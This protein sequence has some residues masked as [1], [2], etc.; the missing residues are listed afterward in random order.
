MSEATFAFGEARL[1]GTFTPGQ[2]GAAD[3]GIGLLLFNAGVVHRVGAHRINVRLA[4]RMARH[5]VP[6]L[7][8]D[9]A[10]LGDSP[11]ATTG[12]GYR[13]QAVADIRAA[14][15]ELSTR[16]GLQRFALFGFC[17]GGV[18]AY[19]VAQADPRV[20]CT[21]LFDTFMYRT[22]WSLLNR[23]RLSIHEKGFW[24]TVG[25]WLGR[26]PKRLR[27]RAGGNAAALEQGFAFEQPSAADFARALAEL[28][29][30]GTKTA[31]VY[32]GGF[33]DMYNYEGQFADAFRGTGVAEFVPCVYDP[34]LDHNATS[35]AAQERLM[36]RIEHWVREAGSPRMGAAG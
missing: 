19:D 11:R 31:I 6:T 10:G 34:Q 17:S 24:S 30:R 16:T 5:G 18:H 26:L 4:R 3:A 7:R 32:S 23:Y 28:H 22:T 1:V 15:D 35:G 33:R 29:A 8:F 9:L 36:A 27:W 12:V 21:V 14:I 2:A 25:G 20:A 13:E